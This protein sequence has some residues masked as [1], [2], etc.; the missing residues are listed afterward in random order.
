MTTTLTRHA[1]MIGVKCRVRSREIPWI[2]VM[3]ML[4]FVH[5]K[6]IPSAVDKVSVNQLF[7]L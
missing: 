7:C 2:L 1:G 3:H 4:S 6:T 5:V